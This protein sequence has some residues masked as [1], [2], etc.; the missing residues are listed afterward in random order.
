MRLKFEM[1]HERMNHCGSTSPFIR[2]DGKRNWIEVTSDVPYMLDETF[3]HHEKL[4]EVSDRKFAR[5]LKLIKVETG[6][7]FASYV[8]QDS[9]D[10]VEL[11]HKYLKRI[12]G[13][14]PRVLY[15]RQVT[16]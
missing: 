3:P 2:F 5:A 12:F 8:W 10:A 15:V 13:R 1:V 7:S 11:C 14:I 6:F 16:S 9:E 4:F